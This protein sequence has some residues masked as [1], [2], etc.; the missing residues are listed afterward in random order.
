MCNCH[1]RARCLSVMVMKVS[2]IMSRPV[3]A[4]TPET[5]IKTAAELLVERAISALP[6]LD[7]NGRLLGIV[8]EAD[9]L[10]IETRPDPRSQATPLP[11]TAGS[12][13]QTVADV[14]TRRVVTVTVDTDVSQAARIMIGAGVKRL[15]V[16]DGGR[17]VG[18]VSR[19]DLVKVIARRDDDI[20]GEVV[21]RLGQLGIGPGHGAI[22]IA[23][24]VAT[25]ELDDAGS[26]RRL[27]ESVALTVPGVL[28]VRFTS[29][30]PSARK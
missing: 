21:R 25:I 8:S 5:A 18:I 2:E 10:P 15:P 20:Q 24:G 22:D 23:A 3:I 6:V 19:R 4:V 29:P 17:V 30:K 27:A 28:E 11:P 12:A 13:P 14:M 9:L 7:S 1:E 16:V 26:A